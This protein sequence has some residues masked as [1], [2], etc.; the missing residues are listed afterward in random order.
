MRAGEQALATGSGPGTELGRLAELIPV[1]LTG[2]RALPVHELAAILVHRA[3]R[4]DVRTA[5]VDG[6][7]LTGI[8]GC[9]RW[10]CPAAAA[11]PARELTAVSRRRGGRRIQGHGTQYDTQEEARFGQG[12]ERR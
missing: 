1:D 4:S 5:V 11:E 7:V 9:S 2:S 8:A 6:T 3:R 10:T 12:C